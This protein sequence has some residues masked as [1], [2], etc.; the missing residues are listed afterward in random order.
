MNLPMNLRGLI[1]AF[2]FLT[3]IPVP[4]VQDVSPQDLSRSAPWFPLVGFAI[5]AAI[6][7]AAAIG[8]IASPWIGALLALFAWVKITGAL[9]ID[10]LADVTDALGAAH[11]SPDRFKDVLKDP[12]V[13]AFGVTAIVLQ[14][15]AK[16]VLVAH[17]IDQLPLRHALPALLLVPA[18]ARWGPLIWSL[19]APSLGPGMGEQFRAE[20]NWMPAALWAA[21]LGLASLWAGPVLIAALLVVPAIAVYWRWRLGAMTGDCLG[22]SVEVTETL[23][24]LVLAAQVL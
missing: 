7:C 13:G 2:Q 14:L 18:W 22:A 15:L 10:A 11:D 9:H 24:L 8:N 3:R 21:V 6:I 17:L 20:L 16:F 12:H 23:L 5:G 1:I 19:A 4:A